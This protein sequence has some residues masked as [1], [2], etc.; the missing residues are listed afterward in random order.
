MKLFYKIS[1]L[2]FIV[3]L[4]VLVYLNTSQNKSIY[5][6]GSIY[7]YRAVGYLKS[8]IVII[9]SKKTIF[10][11]NNLLIVENLYNTDTLKKG[12]M[13]GG[14][15]VRKTS[16]DNN[17]K[18]IY[19]LELFNLRYNDTLNLIPI[20]AIKK[21]IKHNDSFQIETEVN[22]NIAYKLSLRSQKI[23][24]NYHIAETKKTPIDSQIYYVVNVSSSTEF[25]KITG[26]FLFNE[27]SGFTHIFYRLPNN[28]NIT[29]KLTDITTHH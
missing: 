9:P 22:P 26:T 24:F 6:E 2:V 12:I 16:I 7:V 4:L 3:C 29:V 5:K 20:P 17:S 25:G 15:S 18:D 19:S 11:R 28:R 13:Y 8:D 21:E 23:L 10:N 27:N 1:G 14:Y